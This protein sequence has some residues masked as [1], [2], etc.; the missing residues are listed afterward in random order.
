MNLLLDTHAMLWA[1]AEP[2]RLPQNAR[3]AIEDTRNDVWISSA[4]T[5][6]ITIKHA[7]GK[8]ALPT[9]PEIY[10]PARIAHYGFRELA[11]TVAH[12]VALA[13]LPDHHNDPFDRIM[14]AQ[15]QVEGL[16]LVSL[17]AHVTQYRV[18]LLST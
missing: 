17:D 5:W 2:H 1:L 9:A 13:A 4:A 18:R 7:L 8:I 6:E 3:A 16:T 12:T 15:A 10:L 11:I 14:I